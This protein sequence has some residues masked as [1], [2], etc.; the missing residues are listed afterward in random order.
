MGF[1]RLYDPAAATRTPD[2]ATVRRLQK[3]AYYLDDRFRLP[4]TNRRIGL[5]GLLGLLPGI[6]DAATA[7]L[8]GYIIAEAWRLGVPPP[9]LARMGVNWGIDFAVGSIPVVGDIFDVAWKA[10]RKNIDLLLRHLEAE[11]AAAAPAAGG[12]TPATPP[13]RGP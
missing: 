7:A 5:D 12:A 13:R 3:L 2:P 9:T 1:E 8:S 4:G 6:G 11:H 10:N